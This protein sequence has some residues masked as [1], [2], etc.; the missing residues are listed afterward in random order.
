MRLNILVAFLFVLTCYAYARA[1][2]PIPA[3]SP[4][5]SPVCSLKMPREPRMIAMIKHMQKIAHCPKK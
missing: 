4:T 3:P 1:D 2:S 5:V